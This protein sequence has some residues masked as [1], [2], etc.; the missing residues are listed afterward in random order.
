M[1]T[2]Q[3][4]LPW[5]S[6]ALKTQQLCVGQIQLWLKL[7]DSNDMATSF[8]PGLKAAFSVWR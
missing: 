8:T 6:L 5:A 7:R 1:L 4:Q 3:C 2:D